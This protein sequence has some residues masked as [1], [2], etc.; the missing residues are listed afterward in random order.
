MHLL[1]EQEIMQIELYRSGEIIKK[2]D[3]WILADRQAECWWAKPFNEYRICTNTDCKAV[4]PIEEVLWDILN[5]RDSGL[6]KTSFNCTECSSETEEIYEKEYIIQ[7]IKEYFLW[8]VNL[9]LIKDKQSSIEWFWVTSKTTIRSLMEVEFN[10]R[11][12][13]YETEEI[14]KKLGHILYGDENAEDKDVI[15]FHQI[16]L[17]PLIRSSELSYTALKTLF[18]MN[19]NEY[20]DIP[21][22]WETRYDCKFYPI[23]RSIWFENLE[24]DKHWYVIQH[25]PAYSDVLDFLDSHSGYQS[26]LWDM[27]KY[28]KESKKILKENPELVG[29]RFYK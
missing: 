3:I 20:K 28:K 19:R 15:C 17:S 4:F 7:A 9:L 8:E 26:F 10:T 11:I 29:R 12:G 16:Y 6:R 24:H 25:I 14:I 18:E 1:S 13:S 21:T 23:S 2:E 22:V 27:I 5:I